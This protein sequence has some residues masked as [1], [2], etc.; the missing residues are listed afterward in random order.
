MRYDSKDADVISDILNTY[1]I[2]N[3]ITADAADATHKEGGASITA[4]T[5]IL[6][7]AVQK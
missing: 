5:G 6:L 1:S 2:S 4:P 7:F 3:D